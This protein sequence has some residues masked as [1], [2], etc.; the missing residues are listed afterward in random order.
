MRFLP[1]SPLDFSCVWVRCHGPTARNEDA[2]E[3]GLHQ[4][5]ARRCSRKT[6]RNCEALLGSVTVY[7]Q[8]AD[9]EGA[10]IHGGCQAG[11]EQW[12][13]TFSLLCVSMFFCSVL[14]ELYVQGERKWECQILRQAATLSSIICNPFSW[15]ERLQHT[16]DVS[17]PRGKVIFRRMKID[18]QLDLH[19]LKAHN[20]ETRLFLWFPSCSFLTFSRAVFWLNEVT[21]DMHVIKS[22]YYCCWF[23]CLLQMCRVELTISFSKIRTQ[24]KQKLFRCGLTKSAFEELELNLKYWLMNWKTAFAHQHANPNMLNLNKTR[25]DLKQTMLH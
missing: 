11:G 21:C 10:G 24:R 19:R 4:T 9:L 5:H 7:H 6:R 12:K 18:F 2:G 23:L 25:Q 1:S 15:S 13:P 3:P 8:E 14:S 16:V 22:A 20:Y 17:F